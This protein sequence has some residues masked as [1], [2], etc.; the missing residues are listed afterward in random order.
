M[1]LSHLTHHQSSLTLPSGLHRSEVA[2]D[3]GAPS[4]GSSPDQQRPFTHLKSGQENAESPVWWPA[5]SAASHDSEPR[6]P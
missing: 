5:A 3:H 2:R 1:M 4:S 6:R